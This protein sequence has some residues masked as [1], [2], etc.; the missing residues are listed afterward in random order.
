VPYSHVPTQRYNIERRI[1]RRAWSDPEF[2]ARLL[3]NPKAA[4]SEELGIDLPERLQ[5]EAYEE[6]PDR[7]CIVIP[8]DT[9]GVPASTAQVM[10]GLPPQVPPRP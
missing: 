7:M 3:A 1:I 10:M 4:V 6:Q 2:K 8:V 5:V 9:S